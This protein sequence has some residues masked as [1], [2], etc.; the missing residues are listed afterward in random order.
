L[1]DRFCVRACAASLHDALQLQLAGVVN[2]RRDRDERPTGVA[3]QACLSIGGV[4][5][6]IVSDDPR[7][8]STADETLESFATGDGFADVDIRAGWTDTPAACRGEVLFDSGGTWQLLQADRE[9]VFTFRSSVDRSVPYKIARFNPTFTAGDVQLSRR[10][11][12]Q[13]SSDAVY[14]LQY[15]LDELVMIHLLSQGRGVEIHGCALLDCAGRAYVFAGQ[16][17]AGKSTMGRL[18]AD[19]PAVTLLSDER[20]VL[21]TDG[22]RIAVYGTPWHGDAMLASPLSGEL[23]AVFFLNHGPTHAVVPARGS[24]AAAK[25]FACAFLPF[26]SAE[27]VDRTMRAVEQVTRDADC[28]DLWFA[29]D[30]SVIEVLARHMG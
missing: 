7:L 14:A 3:H 20:V 6:R 13:F 25:L 2:D 10:H 24:L 4:T 15:P 27:A 17:G 9:F 16:S 8:A 26:H 5:F 1:Q 22:D 30:R 23:A 21:R 28:Y 29:P 19:Q 11:F 18:W 12:D